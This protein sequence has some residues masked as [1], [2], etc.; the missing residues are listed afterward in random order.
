[1]RKSPILAAVLSVSAGF[2]QAQ[3]TK[4]FT[5]ANVLTMDANF[6]VT[7]AMAIRGNRILSVGTEADVMA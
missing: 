5:N 1:M 4:V 6:S 3:E 2:A 7:E